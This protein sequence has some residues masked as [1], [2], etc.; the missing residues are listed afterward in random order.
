MEIKY[1]TKDRRKH[2]CDGCHKQ[3]P[4]Q[5]FEGYCGDDLYLC[6]KCFIKLME[7]GLN[8]EYTSKEIKK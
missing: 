4:T 8:L 5:K 1:K 6:N 2:G 3:T 7:N